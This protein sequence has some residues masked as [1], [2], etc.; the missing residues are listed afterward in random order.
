MPASTIQVLELQMGQPLL[1]IYL[2]LVL[3]ETRFL[4]WFE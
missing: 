2:F 4:G 1:L 3:F